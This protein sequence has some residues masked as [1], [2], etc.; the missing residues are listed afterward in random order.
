[1]SA[2]APGHTNSLVVYRCAGCGKDIERRRVKVKKTRIGYERTM[3]GFKTIYT[4]T[5]Y[6][7]CKEKRCAPVI[8]WDRR[9]Q[10]PRYDKRYNK[11]EN[12]HEYAST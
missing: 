1:V 4:Y 5:L 11:E 9:K 7:G 12:A 2:V 6:H 10:K 3:R 8:A